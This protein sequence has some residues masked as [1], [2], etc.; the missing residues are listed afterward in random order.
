MDPRPA[1]EVQGIRRHI[2]ILLHGPC[3]GADR[4][5]G[6]NLRNLHDGLEIARAGN[7]EAAFDNVHLHAFKHLCKFDL[8]NRVQLTSRDLFPV[9]QCRVEYIKFLVHDIYEKASGEDSGGGV[10]LSFA[11][12][13]HCC[14][15]MPLESLKNDS[16]AIGPIMKAV[17]TCLSFT[18]NKFRK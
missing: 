1:G 18:A 4:G 16:I 12:S 17:R 11:D 13:L 15:L 14:T 7:G 9:P 5:F 6:D 10:C 2:D 8:L 3:K